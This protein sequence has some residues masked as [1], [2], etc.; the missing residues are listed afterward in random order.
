MKK[1]PL[2]SAF[3]AFSILTE[4]ECAP[5]TLV[6]NGEPRS[7]VVL[8]E[9]PTRAARFAAAEFRHVVKLMTGADIPVSAKRPDSGVAVWIGCGTDEKFAGEEYAVR[10]REDGIVLAGHDAADYGAFDYADAKTLPAIPSQLFPGLIRGH[11]LCLPKATPKANPPISDILM[12][13]TT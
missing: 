1:I 8:G 13:A 9:N 7:T 3:L 11:I 12:I 2:L 10:F 4:C 5:M 6:E